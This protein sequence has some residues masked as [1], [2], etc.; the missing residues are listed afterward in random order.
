M[1]LE[2]RPSGDRLGEQND[3]NETKAAATEI[4]KQSERSE[5]KASN[6]EGGGK[7]ERMNQINVN[8]VFANYFCD[9]LRVAMSKGSRLQTIDR[10]TPSI[11]DYFVQIPVIRGIP[12]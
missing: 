12:T 5:K 4:P 9:L 2:N 6:L 7:E 11:W 1:V 10:K 3:E 8:A